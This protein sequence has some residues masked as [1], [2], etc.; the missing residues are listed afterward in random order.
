MSTVTLPLIDGT[1]VVVPDSLNL[2]TPYVLVEQQDW[3]E[4]EIKFLRKVLRPGQ[5]VIDIG[6]NYGLYT[7]SMAAA[8][9]PQGR[10]WAFEPA[11]STATFLAKSI[12]EN[13]F[14]HITL[15]KC[16]LSSQP[17]TAHLSLND[18]SELN[19]LVRDGNNPSGQSEEVTLTTLDECMLRHG[20]TDIDF[21]KIDAEGEEENILKG[22]QK[23][24][25]SLSP[26]IVYEVKAGTTLHLELT[27]TFAKLGYQSY[28]L[29]PGMNVLT[30]FRQ[31]GTKADPYLL[32]LFCCKPDRAEK[33]AKLGLLLDI[34]PALPATAP[35]K[36]RL[37]DTLAM[38]PY[39]QQLQASWQ[40]AEKAPDFAELAAA[41]SWFALS[42]DGT[43][44]HDLRFAALEHSFK[45]LQ[46]I[47]SRNPSRLRLAS[48][49]RVAATYGARGIA[50][51]A[52][53]RLANT[54]ISQQTVD[55]AEPFL[56]PSYRYEQLA[57]GA[58]LGN[59][60]LSGVLEELERLSSYSSFYV[61]AAGKQRLEAICG[62]GFASPEMQRRLQLVKRRFGL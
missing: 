58:Q 14:T 44:A 45:C 50:V 46:D 23:F 13:G 56:A 33:L 5:Q 43:Q 18:N 20:W 8:I 3:F 28:R 26:L 60:I 34:A 7:V 12:A 27:E 4:D 29:V 1:R 52:L 41:L 24:F 22:G 61:G 49:A 2:I 16:A 37:S 62:L 57:P 59:W 9:G 40:Q 32:N 42:Q 15:E 31:D 35:E 51:D 25:T 21:M 47:C 39:G 10:A 11:S 54:I 6:A 30:P 36:Y 53:N 55:P 48:L 19:E 17:G 38:L